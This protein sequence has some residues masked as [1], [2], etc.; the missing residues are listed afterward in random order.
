MLQKTNGKRKIIL[1]VFLAFYLS[2]LLEVLIRGKLRQ[3]AL[4]TSTQIGRAHV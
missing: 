3:W 4:K 2:K 1:A